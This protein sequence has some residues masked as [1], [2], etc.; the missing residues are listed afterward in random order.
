MR[1]IRKAQAIIK[2]S[3]SLILIV[4]FSFALLI[5]LAVFLYSPPA[6]SME[7]CIYLNLSFV[8]CAFD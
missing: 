7:M 4:S 8:K 5:H 6:S 2:F 1:I 3:I